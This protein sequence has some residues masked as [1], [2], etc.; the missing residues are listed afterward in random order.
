MLISCNRNGAPRNWLGSPSQPWYPGN[1]VEDFVPESF[2]SL[3]GTQREFLFDDEPP[4]V[5]PAMLAGD[6][7]AMEYLG[8]YITEIS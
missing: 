1:N 3:S 2:T 6:R 5:L 8:K 4:E 7:Y